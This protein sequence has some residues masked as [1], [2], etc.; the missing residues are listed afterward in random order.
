MRRHR[1]TTRVECGAFMLADSLGNL[2]ILVAED[3]PD[4][5]VLIERFLAL[6]GANVGTASNGEEAVAKVLDSHC[7]YDLVL[8][9]IQMPVMDGYQALA[10]L[11]ESGFRRPVIALTA[12]ALTFEKERCLASGFDDYLTKP[13]D[14]NRLLSTLRKW[15]EIEPRV[16]H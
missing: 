9:D 5:R 14:R 16:L 3:S 2:K 1:G 8:M 10:K 13:I 15:N 7:D 6:N 12:H 11:R 4:N